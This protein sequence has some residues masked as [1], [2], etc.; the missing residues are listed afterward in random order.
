MG[1]LWGH[2]EVILSSFGALLGFFLDYVW[3]FLGLFLGLILES[4][5]TLFGTHLGFF[6]DSFGTLFGIFLDSFSEGVVFWLLAAV[7]L[8]F[9]TK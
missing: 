5:W 3:I 7:W 8:P 9:C 6:L 2:F 4:F 1:H